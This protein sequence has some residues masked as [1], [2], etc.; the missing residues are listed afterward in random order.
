MNPEERKIG[1]REIATKDRKRRGEQKK[2]G[3]AEKEGE[4]R[5]R[6]GEQK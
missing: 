1:R 5:E 3:K 4:S 2:K 6:R